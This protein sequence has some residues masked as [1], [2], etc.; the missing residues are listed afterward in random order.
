M[1]F[2]I[3]DPVQYPGWDKLLLTHPDSSFFHTSSW[4][5]VLRTYDYKPL[6]FVSIHNYRLENLVPMMEVSS[7]LTGKRGVSLPFTDFCH[8]ILAPGEAS[9]G[10]IAN[11][12]KWGQGVKWKSIDFRSDGYKFG[13]VAPRATYR[14]HTVALRN[15]EHELLRSFRSS[16]RRNIQKARKTGVNA[17]CSRSL[18]ALKEFYRLHVINRKVHGLP[19]QP[20]DFFY[21]I[22]DQILRKKLGTVV[23]ATHDNR[24]VAGAVIFYF[25]R[26]A[27]YK[28]GASDRK[29]LQLR[30]NNLVFWEAMRHCIRRGIKRYSLGRTV[31][32][33]K[34]LLQFKRGWTRDE[35]SL[36]YYRYDLRRRRF[37]SKGSMVK[38]GYRIFQWMPVSMLKLCGKLLYRHIA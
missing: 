4:A 29:Y 3:I 19:P 28:F 18:R 37:V 24:A 11:V 23:L 17:H 5:Q 30:P 14:V 12:L 38:E 21:A 8:P 10:F 9:R 15:A 27:I 1:S 36:G 34:G 22:F 32:Q 6:Y 16:T 35:S 31:P 26:E 33:N 7:P 13:N 20:F 25:G 2:D